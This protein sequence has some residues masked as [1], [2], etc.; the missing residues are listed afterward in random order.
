MDLTLIPW[1]NKVL[2]NRWLVFFPRAVMLAGFAFTIVVGFIG[3][4]VGGRNFAIMFVWI[5]WWTVLKLVLIPFGGRSWCSICPIPVPGEWLQQRFLVQPQG[6]SPGK[7]HSWP[8]KLRG[9]WLQLLGFAFMGLFSAFLLTKPAATSWILL[10]LCIL[11]FGLSLIYDRRSF[12]R[13]L[14]PIGG[15]IGWYAQLAPIEVRARDQ[16]ICSQHTPKTCFTGCAEGPGCPWGLVPATNQQNLDCGLC[17]ECQRTCPYD[18][19]AVRLRPFGHDLAVVNANRTLDRA[20]FG[21]FILACVPVYSAMMLGYWGALKTA[22]YSVGSTA[23][24]TYA[25]AFL[26]FTLGLVPGMFAIAVYGGWRWRAKGDTFRGVFI[27]LAYSFA[28]LGLMAWIAFTISF[29]FGKLAYVWPVLS[30]PFGWGWDLFGT[31]H[32]TWHPY[33]QTITPIVQVMILGIGLHWTATWIKRYAGFRQAF[34]VLIFAL[35]YTILALGLLI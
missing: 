20:W 23:W 14:C 34:P 16:A 11:A 29:A 7:R 18:N 24:F 17:M 6:K 35:T 2:R 22:A 33:L 28:P 4:G 30:D 1:I 9:S 27:R 26:L 12:C 13:Y 21:L 32:W 19:M 10:F 25:A 3:T 31:A 15:Y 8:K 5:A